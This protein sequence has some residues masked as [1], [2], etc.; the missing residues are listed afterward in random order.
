[1]TQS[2]ADDLL[3]R[4]GELLN[5]ATC[6]QSDGRFGDADLLIADA[7]RLATGNVQAC[8]EVELFCATAL[9]E[10]GNREHGLKALSSML[11]RHGEWLKTAEGRAV[12]ERVQV[13]RALSLM[14]FQRNL[15]AQPLLEEATQF[16][17]DAQVRS[18]VYCHLGRCYHELSLYTLAREQFER[19][20]ALGVSED[21]QPAFHYYY[22]YTLYELKE[23]QRAKRE[24][25]L[26]L[27]SGS[28]GPEPALRYSMLAATSRKLGEYSEAGT[29]EERAKKL[30]L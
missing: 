10:H 20:D 22:G 11:A 18:D 16:Q 1:M 25:I 15:E 30:K 29:Y 12:Y 5:K 23:F 2:S 21:W 8:A 14:H 9:L 19:A 24:F 7:R 28:S 13:Q 4:I 26:C 17:I 27:Q 3:R 6:C